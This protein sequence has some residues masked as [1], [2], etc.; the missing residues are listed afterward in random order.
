MQIDSGYISP[1][2]V[3]NGEEGVAE[4][5]EPYILV[6]EETLSDMRPLCPLLE[7]IA[8]ADKALLIIAG[9][10]EGDV[11]SM[12]VLNKRRGGLR[13]AAVKAPGS[14]EHLKAVLDDV[15]TA[16][17]GLVINNRLGITLRDVT[18]DMLGR[19]HKVLVE[20]RRTTIV[21]GAGNKVRL[22]AVAVERQAAV[23]VHR[24]R[25]A[26]RNKP[27]A[28]GKKFAAAA[29]AMIRAVQEG[30]VAFD[31]LRRMKQKELVELYPKARRTTLVQSREAALAELKGSDH[32]DRTPT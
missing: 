32:F 24:E 5:T 2:F 16:T 29:E 4:L 17:G 9:D 1:F 7:D 26:I 13:V 23:R 12:L 14:G 11:L 28:G 6:H 18:L 19:A 21:G 10:V 25:L 20:K 30:R 3:T 8:I 31:V 22:A 27:G 15:A